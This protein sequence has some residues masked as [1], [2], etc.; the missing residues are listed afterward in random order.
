MSK[1]KHTFVAR[2]YPLINRKTDSTV[3]E[4]SA[5]FMRYWLDAKYTPEVARLHAIELAHNVR[6][7]YPNP[8]DCKL[9]ACG[10]INV[11]MFL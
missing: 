4:A 1:F 7:A 6:E 2:D 10:K 5:D 9:L 8:H 3:Y 11:D